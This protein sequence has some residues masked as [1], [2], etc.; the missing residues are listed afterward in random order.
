M[1]SSNNVVVVSQPGVATNTVIVERQ[2]V[3]HCLHFIITL[4]FWPWI[5]VWIILCVME[6]S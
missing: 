4:F 2:G 6:G 3:N 1:Q 5:I